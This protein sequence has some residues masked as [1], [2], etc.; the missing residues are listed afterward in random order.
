MSFRAAKE[1]GC[2][3][4]FFA[5]RFASDSSDRAEPRQAPASSPQGDSRQGMSVLKPLGFSCDP[6]GR[7]RLNWTVQS[8]RLRGS[9]G[10]IRDKLDKEYASH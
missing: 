1:P 4:F 9:F 5:I 2:A 10:G 6:E 3:T 7:F 8:S